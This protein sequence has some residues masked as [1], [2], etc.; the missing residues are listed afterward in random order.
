MN[1]YV[2]FASWIIGSLCY[3]NSL[4]ISL[5]NI[6]IKLDHGEKDLSTFPYI[7]HFKSVFV[8]E[9]F[10]VLS[11]YYKWDYAIELVPRA[12]FK[13]SKI[14]LLSSTKQLELDTFLTKNIHTRSFKSSMATLVFFIKKKNGFL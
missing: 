10:N 1:L 6:L 5:R 11:D 12:E 13:S 9:N 3:S 8:K 4:A 2:L 14:Y 7:Q